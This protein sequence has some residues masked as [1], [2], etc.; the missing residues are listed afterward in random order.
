MQQSAPARWFSMHFLKGIEKTLAHNKRGH[1]CAMQRLSGLDVHNLELCMPL[2]SLKKDGVHGFRV[3]L[4]WPE[5]AVS[6]WLPMYVLDVLDAVHMGHSMSSGW[7][8]WCYV[9]VPAT[10]QQGL[11]PC[12]ECWLRLCVAG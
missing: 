11:Q 5:G 8:T 4:Q 10:V 6:Q 7:G 1:H 12:P 3:Y 2:K 9:L